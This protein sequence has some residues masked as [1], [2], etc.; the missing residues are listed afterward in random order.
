MIKYILYV[1]ITYLTYKKYQSKK[2][3]NQRHS[4][5]R[6]IRKNKNTVDNYFV[7]LTE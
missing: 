6:D 3:S 5:N 7:G 1:Y 2:K 4:M